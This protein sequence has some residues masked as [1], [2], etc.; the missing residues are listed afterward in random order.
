M[1]LAANGIGMLTLLLPQGHFRNAIAIPVLLW[2]P[3]NLR[4][5][6]TGKPVEDYLSAVQVSVALIRYLD[7]CTFKIPEQSLRR[8]GA[9]G[10]TETPQ[11]IQNMT[12]WQKLRWNFDLFTTLRGIGWNWRVKNVDD[13]PKDISRR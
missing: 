12:L 11:E 3:Y 10:S 13:V 8:V 9:D 7:F 6:T 4:R 2:I 5:Y 1:P